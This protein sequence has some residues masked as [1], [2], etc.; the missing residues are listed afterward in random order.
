MYTN[1]RW[2]NGGPV[3]DPT[4]PRGRQYGIAGIG[5]PHGDQPGPWY[6]PQEQQESSTRRSTRKSGTSSAATTAR[7]AACTTSSCGRT[8]TETLRS[9]ELPKLDK[10]STAVKFGDWMTVIQQMIGDAS[11]TSAHWWETT[12]TAVEQSYHQWLH[13]DPLMRLRL[14]PVVPDAVRG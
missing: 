6:R 10:A 13:A 9:V 12:M 14:A 11:Y 8:P 1:H 4:N 5:P 3:V 2:M 7:R